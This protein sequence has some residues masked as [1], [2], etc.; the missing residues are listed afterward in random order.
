MEGAPEDEHDA[1]RFFEQTKPQNHK[2]FEMWAVSLVEGEP[3]EKK[4]ADKGIDGKLYFFDLD[5][6]TRQ[7]FIQVKGGGTNP[8]DVR[9]FAN[10][11]ETNGAILGLFLCFHITEQMRQAADTAGY[12]Q[13]FGTRKIPRIQLITFRE[14]LEDKKRFEIPEGFRVPRSKGV[15]KANALQGELML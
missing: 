11:V 14:L 15:G 5:G 3:Q 4:G 1:R 7:G 12:A 6:K 8:N 13:T 9:A 2:P 10:V